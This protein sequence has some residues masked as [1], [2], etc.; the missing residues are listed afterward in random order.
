MSKDDDK[1]PFGSEP[2]ST[3]PFGRPTS[4]GEAFG[5]PAPVD[6]ST[7]PPTASDPWS[8][9][10]AP[11]PPPPPPPTASDAW[12]TG[13][14]PPPSGEYAAPPTAGRKADGAIAALVLGIIGVIFCPL[15][16]PIAWGLGRKAERLVDA[17]GRTLGGRGEATT[18]KVLGMIGTGLMIIGII[19]FIA[20]VAF[21]TSIESGGSTSTT[22]EF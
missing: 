4:G 21:G 19:L 17:S 8:T 9:R 18:G 12:R 13:P 11:P 1:N 20:L 22:F 14:A 7:S 15:C 10:S 2:S 3:D 16:A 5:T 6:P